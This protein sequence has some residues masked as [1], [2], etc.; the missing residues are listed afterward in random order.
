MYSANEINKIHLTDRIQITKVGMTTLLFNNGLVVPKSLYSVVDHY[1]NIKDEVKNFLNLYLHKG[2]SQWY[3][4]NVNLRQQENTVIKG[5]DKYNN[6]LHGLLNTNV[7]LFINGYKILPSQYTINDDFSITILNKYTDRF[8]SNVVIFTSNYAEYLG[9]V[10]A[11]L[12]WDPDS[13]SLEVL[14]YT[15][16]RYMFFLNGQLIPHNDLHYF[17]GKLTI[18]KVLRPGIDIVD[19][20]RLPSDTVNCLFEETPG[21]FSYGPKDNYETI[22]PEVYDT[23]VEFSD[24]IVRLSI[25]DCRPGFFIREEGKAGCIMITDDDYESKSVK[26][27]ELVPFSKDQ[28]E[29]YA[30]TEYY[31]QV[32]QARSIINYIS[33]FDLNGKFFPEIL[34]VFQRCLLDETYDSIQ[35]LKNIRSIEKVDSS[36]I[37][38]LIEFMGVKINLKPMT[39]E[40]KHA[41]LEELTN[42]YK[43]VGTKVSYNFYNVTTNKS[44]ILDIEQLFTPIK[45][46]NYGLDPIQRYVTFR[47]AEELGAI[48]HREYVYPYTDYGEVGTLANPE[49]SLTNMP[50]SEGIL[51]YPD[52]PIFSTDK[53]PVWITNDQGESVLIEK[54]V[55]P[56]E[57]IEPPH[58]GPNKP[59]ID[60]GWI[61]D[62]PVN[63]YDWGLVSDDIKGKWI[64]WFEWDRPTNWYPTNHVNVSIE[65]PPAVDYTTFMN[66][67]KRTFY[68][69]ASAVLY[70]HSVIDVY[71]FGDDKLW[72][73]GQKPNFGIMTS[74]LYHEI[75]HTFTNNPSIKAWIPIPE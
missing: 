50:R 66:E 44:R 24:H 13:N 68:D 15:T 71:T 41:L 12:T 3:E 45:D 69:I 27:I 43:I 33:Q 67:F 74:L 25:D 19:Y 29:T 21:Y 61:T 17:E 60:Y 18:N 22:V 53:W 62:E 2:Q 56:N 16:L 9:N 48:Y 8:T 26:C 37:N 72:E 59:T 55:K 31:I 5:Y 23:I 10:E 38:N 30:N 54:D 65:V 42:F 63:F 49:D 6:M 7:I 28:R 70:I 40:E 46:I 34:G 20:Y 11:D 64:E 52:Y 75:E 39:L 36:N 51:K 4:Y 73:E 57:Y 58:A 32:P 35:R 1:I 14:D 47:T